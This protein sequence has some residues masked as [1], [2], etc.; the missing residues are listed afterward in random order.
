MVIGFENPGLLMAHQ[1]AKGHLLK[2]A[3]MRKSMLLIVFLFIISYFFAADFVPFEKIKT[4]AL[5][6][7][8]ARWGQVAMGPV[9]AAYDLNGE[10]SCYVFTFRIGCP[11]FPSDAEIQ[12]MIEE[13]EELETYERVFSAYPVSNSRRTS[14]VYVYDL[15][16]NGYPEVIESGDSARYPS[17]SVTFIWEIEGVRLHQPNGG[18]VLQPG[19]QFP[20]TW[21]KFTPPGADSF[22][23]FISF[24]NGRNYQTITTIQQSND[25]LYLWNVPDS[26]SDSCKIMIW[27]YGPPRP[28]EDKPRG[29]A[30]DFSDSVFAIR[31]TKVKEAT[32]YSILDTGLKILL[33]PT[34]REIRLQIKDGRSQK[35]AL[36]IYD[37]SGKLVKD[38]SCNIIRDKFF[39]ISLNPGVYFITFSLDDKTVTK[40]VVVVE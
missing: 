15:N 31:E 37:I 30:W 3:F 9:L 1:M 28:G 23:L 12:A 2:G 18:E 4:I 24:D 14:Q 32:R 35:I 7:A 22:T 16:G 8:Q 6:R 26:L 33:N 10:I 27:A 34:R 20:I 21:E 25:T 39:T 13:G 11:Y 29:T 36:K 19:S 40:K 5:A 38:L 17:G